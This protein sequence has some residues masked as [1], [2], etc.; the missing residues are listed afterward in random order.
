MSKILI[1]ILFVTALCSCN[2]SPEIEKVKID[3]NL[4]P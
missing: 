2:N 1:L 3:D 4:K